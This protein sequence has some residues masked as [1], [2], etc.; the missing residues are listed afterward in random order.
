M[1]VSE[2]LLCRVGTRENSM[3]DEMTQPGFEQQG[4]LEV[5]CGDFFVVASLLLGVQEVNAID[6]SDGI[7]DEGWV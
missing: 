3:R 7:C 4:P 2:F 5:A 1:R 6:D